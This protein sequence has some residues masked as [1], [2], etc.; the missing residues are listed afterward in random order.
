MSV[1]CTGAHRLEVSLFMLRTTLCSC[2]LLI[3]IVRHCSSHTA[4]RI[5]MSSGTSGV[6][7]GL[8]G[9]AILIVMQCGWLRIAKKQHC[10]LE[11]LEAARSEVVWEDARINEP[12]TRHH[13]RTGCYE[14]QRKANPWTTSRRIHETEKTWFCKATLRTC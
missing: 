4:T 3:L 13:L 9:F 2:W 1:N 7:F 14:I 11:L 12:P 8:W 5:P 10:S 6:F